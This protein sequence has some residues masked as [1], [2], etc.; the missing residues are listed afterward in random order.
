MSRKAAALRELAPEERVARPGE[1]RSELMH[2]RGVASMGAPPA[3]PGR[4]R[5]LRKQV[6]RLQTVM[7]DLGER[8]G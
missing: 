5:S 3:S 1:L 2:G 4:R 7:R 6:A 8:Y